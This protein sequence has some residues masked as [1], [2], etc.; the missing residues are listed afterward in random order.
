MC[1]YKVCSVQPEL[2]PTVA[3]VQTAI[4]LLRVCVAF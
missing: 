1:G 4:L 3:T 2:K